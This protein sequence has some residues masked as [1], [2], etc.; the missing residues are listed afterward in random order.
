M[1]YH[2]KCDKQF[3]RG[4]E[5]LAQMSCIKPGDTVLDLGCGT[6]QLACYMAEIVGPTGKMVG[7]DPDQERIKIAKDSYGHLKNV[8][9]AVGSSWEFPNM[10]QETYDLIFSSNVLHWIPK[11]EHVFRNAYRSLKPGGKIAIR[12]LYE[13]I[14]LIQKAAVELFPGITEGILAMFHFEDMA[15]VEEY[16]LKAGFKMEKICIDPSHATFEHTMDFCEWMS[17]ITHGLADLELLI[18]ERLQ[19]FDPPVVEGKIIMEIP[20][21]LRLLATKQ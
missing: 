8:T 19:K 10:D 6:G 9:F 16:C 15:L 12:C 14:P 1:D 17:A 5:F 7:V 20:H 18:P 11:K 21:V 4:R 3:K 2:N 13:M